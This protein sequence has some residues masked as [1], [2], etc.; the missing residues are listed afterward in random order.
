MWLRITHT[1]KN[2][3]FKWLGFS[4]AVFILTLWQTF[5]GS[6]EGILLLAWGWFAGNLIPGLTMLLLAV[7]LDRQLAR[8]I[9]R[10]AHRVL[11]GLTLVY[12]LAVLITLI[13]EP[14]VTGNPALNM[15]EY[16]YHSFLWLVPLQFLLLIGYSML[17]FWKKMFLYPNEV[18][19]R[20]VARS[21]MESETGPHQELRKKILNR[22][23]EN[24]IEEALQEVA[25][26]IQVTGIGNLE[27]VVILQARW[28][29]NKR[30]EQL[31]LQSPEQ[32]QRNYNQIAVDLM[33]LA[34][35]L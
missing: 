16:R 19:V 14:A 2:C 34:K 11:V 17:F 29:E 6:L 32:L 26:T 18:E 21:E 25:D 4:L 9:P 24:K 23:A 33:E 30:Q 35:R 28:R 20:R 5:S 1:K 8:L 31:D 12:L 22:I 3:L 7:L 15:E 13:L 10:T 27:G